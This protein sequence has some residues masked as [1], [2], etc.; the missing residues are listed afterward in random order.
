M[1]AQ[2][3]QTSEEL[4]FGSFEPEPQPPVA[5]PQPPP[6]QPSDSERL[7]LLEKQLAAITSKFN[8]AQ[9]QLMIAA[10]LLAK[11][12]AKREAKKKLALRIFFQNVLEKNKLIIEDV[13]ADIFNDEVF[14]VKQM[15]VSYFCKNI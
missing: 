14:T 1:A 8:L 12:K 15:G 10:P 3:Q 6:A 2:Q 5:Q 4:L 11:K 7:A 9:E 13:W